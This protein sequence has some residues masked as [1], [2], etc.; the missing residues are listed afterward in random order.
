MILFTISDL[1]N[2]YLVLSCSYTFK[3]LRS[4]FLL[5]LEVRVAPQP[6]SKLVLK[7]LLN[8][9]RSQKDQWTSKCDAEIQSE[10]ETIESGTLASEER[11]L[12]DSDPG[13]EQHTDSVSEAI[14]KYCV[15]LQLN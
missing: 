3:S 1:H 6:Q 12:C 4:V 8:K 2:V 13:H 9:I 14:G 11:R 10:I 15:A 7:K 5:D